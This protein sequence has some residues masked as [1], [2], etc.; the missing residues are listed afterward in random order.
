MQNPR[1]YVVIFLICFATLVFEL[2]LVRLFSV[3]MFYH[4]AFLAVSLA[5]FG[6]GAAGLYV[7]VFRRRFSPA[8]LERTVMSACILFALAVPG[9]MAIILRIPIALNYSGGNIVRLFVIYFASLIPFLCSGLAISVILFHR[10]NDISRLY[11]W[12]LTGAALGA[13]CTV[14]L[15]NAIGP[16]DAALVTAAVAA[17]AAVLVSPGAR[18]AGRWLAYAVLAATILLLFGNVS[19]GFLDLQSHKGL[20]KENVVF[21]KWNSFSHVCVREFP[22]QPRMAAI[23]IDA[24]ART[25]ILQE[26]FRTMTRAEIREIVGPQWISSIPNVLLDEGEVLIVGPGG[27]MDVVFA[28]AWGARRIDA[29]EINPIII[30]DIMLKSH[31][32]YSGGLYNRRDVDVHVAEGRAFIRRSEKR[33]D[34]I[35]LALVDTWAASSAGAFSLTENNLYTV[36]AFRD[37]LTHL[38][39]DGVCAVTRWL[40]P[41][42]RQALRVMTTMIAA[43]TELGIASPADHI[44]VVACNAPGMR[45]EMATVIFKSSPLLPQDMAAL[46]DQ[47]SRGAGRVVYSPFDR[48]DNAFSDYARAAD[49]ERFYADY[50]FDV[51]PTV[52]NRPFFFNTVRFAELGGILRLER[53][54]QKNNLCIFNLGILSALSVVAVVL[55]FFGPLLSGRERRCLRETPGAVRQMLYFVSIGLG[56]ILLEMALMQSFVLYLEHPVHALAVVLSCLLVSAGIGSYFTKRFDALS[57]RRYGLILFAGIAAVILVELFVLP[58]VLAA[59]YGFSF[60]VRV[61]V[62]V[63]AVF[64]LGFLLGQPFPLEIMYV[65]RRSRDLVPWAW[66][67]NCAASVLGSVAAVVIAM[68]WGFTAVIAAGFGAYLLAA[69]TRSWRARES[70]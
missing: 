13:M 38:T 27:G 1:F 29:V 43:A 36:E 66:G 2:S 11:F 64:P 49:R 52:D 5:L 6:L 63:L 23:I 46:K 7:F 18:T 51:R 28:L 30:N 69:A 14:P 17:V 12:D 44:A 25:Y 24:D 4:F 41:K 22:D 47:L 61:G 53:D 20:G 62:S 54:S 33:Y 26:P 10:A 60:A 56:F 48:T 68:V 45:E 55:C 65:E 3:I 59:T 9:G 15:L 37:Y 35:Q 34:M 40:F 50:E 21:E 42:P 58:P 8:S 39:P 67:L 57:G 16:I 32:L 31:R 19:T 70:A